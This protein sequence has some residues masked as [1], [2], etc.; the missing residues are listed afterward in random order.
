MHAV[1]VST[2]IYVLKT[3]TIQL[4]CTCNLKRTLANEVLIPT[5][6]EGNYKIILLYKL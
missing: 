5:A 3:S 4:Y 6:A 1:V 2:I